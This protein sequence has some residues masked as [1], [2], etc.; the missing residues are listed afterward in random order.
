[1]ADLVRGHG[2]EIEQSGAD[3]VAVI[4]IE[5]EIAVEGDGGV[6]GSERKGVEAREA[7][8]LQVCLAS[9]QTARKTEAGGHEGA[10]LSGGGER[11]DDTV[12]RLSGRIGAHGVGDEV[13]GPYEDDRARCADDA[14]AQRRQVGID[15]YGNGIGEDILPQ[16]CGV[17]EGRQRRTRKPGPRIDVDDQSL[18]RAARR[19]CEQRRAAHQQSPGRAKSGRQGGGTR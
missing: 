12:V 8:R 4:E 14:G 16:P 6:E 11:G 18:G 9:T 7:H 3:P 2:R 15:V 19:Q 10:K 5:G 13:V 17:V 1:M